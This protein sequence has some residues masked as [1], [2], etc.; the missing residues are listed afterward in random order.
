M[1]FSKCLLKLIINVYIQKV[2]ALSIFTAVVTNGDLSAED[3]VQA[4]VDSINSKQ[5][6][7]TV[8]TIYMF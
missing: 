7:W 1:L 5:S 2:M 4:F 6:T 8:S 3:D